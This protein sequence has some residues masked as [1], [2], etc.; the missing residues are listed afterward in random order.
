LRVFVG[1][2]RGRNDESGPEKRADAFIEGV[3]WPV[4]HEELQAEGKVSAFADGSVWLDTT[5][6][7][8]GAVPL[9]D[10]DERIDVSVLYGRSR[11]GTPMSLHGARL[12]G[13]E[14]EPLTER[15]HA[16]YFADRLIH[17]AAVASE[18]D[19]QLTAV[20]TSFRGLREWLMG[21]TEDTHTP[22]PLVRPKPSEEADPEVDHR[23]EE[24]VRVAAVEIDGVHVQATV[25]RS[26]ASIG[27][28]RTVYDTSASLRLEAP[29]AISLTE[30]RRLWIEP[31]R[32][33]VLFGTREQTV[34]LS[35][36][37]DLGT[38]PPTLTYPCTWPP[39][40]LFTRRSTT[41]TTSA[42]SFRRVYGTRTASPTFLRAGGVCTL[43]SV[44]WLRR[45]SSC[46][47]HPTSLR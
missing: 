28:F 41:S 12:F 29:E 36:S 5:T 34:M 13:G 38:T 14:K 9:T 10:D 4:G 35:L 22:L 16:R 30:W 24:W 39:R 21:W 7:A 18:D 45:S 1:A 3:W 43:T 23:V 40:P 19:L 33:L 6:D 47:T 31:L 46:R 11:S 42:T 25:S 32:D 20:R 15:S 44:R 8:W 37:G 2:A 27:R 26:P 17:G